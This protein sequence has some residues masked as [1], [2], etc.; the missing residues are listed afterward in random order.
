MRIENTASDAA[1]RLDE[2]FEQLRRSIFAAYTALVE[3]NHMRVAEDD[4]A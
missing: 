1:A 3:H 2:V 4:R